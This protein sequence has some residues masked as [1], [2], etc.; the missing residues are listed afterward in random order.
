V[1]GNKN[2][3]SRDSSIDEDEEMNIENIMKLN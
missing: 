2:Y 1:L 3:E